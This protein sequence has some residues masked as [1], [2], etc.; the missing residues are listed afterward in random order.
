MTQQNNMVNK[1]TKNETNNT[2]QIKQTIM[3]TT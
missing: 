1:T 2:T 3:T